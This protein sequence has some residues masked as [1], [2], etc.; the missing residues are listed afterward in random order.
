MPS[1]RTSPWS[2]RF[3]PPPLLTRRRVIIACTNCR[4]RKIRCLN[5]EDMPSKPC[6]R[7]T[8]KGL[9][10][11]YVTIGNERDASSPNE[12]RKQ[13]VDLNS[14]SSGSPP[15]YPPSPYQSSSCSLGNGYARPFDTK[16]FPS[17]TIRRHPYLDPARDFTPR[18]SYEA[19]LPSPTLAVEEYNSHPPCWGSLSNISG[20]ETNSFANADSELAFAVAASVAFAIIL[21]EHVTLLPDEIRLYRRSVWTTIPPYGFLALRYGGILTT[22]PMLFLSTVANNHC[23]A[24]ASISQVGIVLVVAATGTIF[25][26]RTSLSWAYHWTIR[27]GLSGMMFAV[28]GCWI[29]L[30]TQ[31]RAVAVPHPFG[32]NCSVL[33]TV[34]WMPLGNATFT[35]F[36]FIALLLTILKFHEHRPRNSLVAHLIYRANLLYLTGTTLTAAATLIIQI[37]APPSG[38]LALSTAPIAAVF[39]VAFGTRA[40]RNMMLLTSVETPR[41]HELSLANRNISPDNNTFSDTTHI[42]EMRFAQPHPPPTRPLPPVV[43]RPARIPRSPT[44]GP[45]RPRTADS[46]RTRPRTT[47]SVRPHTSDSADPFGLGSPTIFSSPPS[48]YA[49]ASL[50]SASFASHSALSTSPLRPD[51]SESYTY[52]DQSLLSLSPPDNP[53]FIFH[54]RAL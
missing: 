13:D 19:A 54:P 25:T 51:H 30:A 8:T 22:L 46:A 53:D 1:D 14:T 15:A 38:P 18:Y 2:P 10:C 50:L 21:W 47:A 34:P 11:R 5:A 39:T 16:P 32:S 27:G 40:A 28:T 26:A 35:V 29:A 33:P 44:T 6:D 37:L 42:S 36:L 24:A 17:P 4:K 20:E 41:A 7:C 52:T 45:P 3:I 43:S 31:Y 9:D 49:D 48:S 12:N 23:Q